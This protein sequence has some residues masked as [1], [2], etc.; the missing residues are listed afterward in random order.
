MVLQENNILYS[1]SVDF[2]LKYY[3]AECS[4]SNSSEGCKINS[5]KKNNLNLKLSS[6]NT[7]SSY[8]S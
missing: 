8:V 3:L 7:N 6:Y 2:F 5:H 1:F 4:D